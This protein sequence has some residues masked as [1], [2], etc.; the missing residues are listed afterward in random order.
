MRSEPSFECEVHKTVDGYAICCPGKQTKRLTD[1]HWWS[2]YS[3]WGY[4]GRRKYYKIKLFA[5][6]K[7]RRLEN[8]MINEMIKAYREEQYRKNFVERKVWR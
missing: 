1:N 7:A 3:S 2:N 5:I 4:R 6:W 8:E